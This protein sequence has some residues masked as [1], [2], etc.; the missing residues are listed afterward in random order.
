MTISSYPL[1]GMVDKADIYVKTETLVNGSLEEALSVTAKV[2]NLRCRF[3]QLS[4]KDELERRGF[5]SGKTWQVI[6]EYDSSIVQGDI[7]QWKKNFQN[8]Q[9]VY[10]KGQRD[11]YGHYHHLTLLVE[12]M[13][14]VT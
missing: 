1:E 8:F 5:A 7:I 14:F 10:V 6:S 12:E 3:T 2:S 13:P 9:V 11:E 4:A